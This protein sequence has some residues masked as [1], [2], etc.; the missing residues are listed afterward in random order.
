MR[1]LLDRVGLS[2]H[3]G[4]FER[5]EVDAEAFGQ[6]SNADLKELGI[7]DKADRQAILN[8]IKKL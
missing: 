5:E 3:A 7:S 1:S 4:L 8:V 2:R 6:L